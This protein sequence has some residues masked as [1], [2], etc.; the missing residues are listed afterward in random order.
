MDPER[1]GPYE[2]LRLL[3]PGGLGS[4]HLALDG[5][6]RTVAVKAIHPHLVDT[7]GLLGL[8]REAEAMRGLRS[9]H[10]AEI[11]DADLRC[12]SPYIVSRYVQGRS[13]DRIV[14]ERGP[15][16]GVA[17]TALYTGLAEALAV[18]HREGVVHRDLTPRNV[19]I[20]D[21]VPVV[22]DLGIAQTLGGT[23]IT[24]GVVGT[25]GY[26]APELIEGERAG[27][28]ADVFAWAATVVFAATGR[29]CFG[30][31]TTAEIVNNVLTRRP[32]LTGVPA[33]RSSTAS[34]GPWTRTRA[35]GRRRAS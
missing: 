19:M 34:T 32:D 7:G 10:V 16:S 29:Q 25:A 35:A 4:V 33:R 21:G 5:D 9:P 26:V 15:F 2:V 30:G 17:L 28:A 6:G 24:Q 27:P 3:G 8:E 20:A 13:L 1:I 11:L 14:T 31:R 18:I 12:A 22:V 23:R